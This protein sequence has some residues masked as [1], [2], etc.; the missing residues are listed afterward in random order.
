MISLRAGIIFRVAFPAVWFPFRNR[1]RGCLPLEQKPQA[2]CLPQ[3]GTSS[4]LLI[5]TFLFLLDV[6][7]F[8]GAFLL[9]SL[10]AASSI[11]FQKF[12][13]WHLFR[14]SD[15]QMDLPVRIFHLT[16]LRRSSSGRHGRFQ[17]ESAQCLHTGSRLWRMVEGEAA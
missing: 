7:H 2:A 16:C 4:Y 14:V 5:P 1:R 8:E 3:H 15:P 9:K 6:G 17:G 10:L 13:V 12:C 11:E